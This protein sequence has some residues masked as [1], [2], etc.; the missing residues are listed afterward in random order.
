MIVNGSALSIADK[1]YISF[2]AVVSAIGAWGFTGQWSYTIL[3]AALGAITTALPRIII[4]LTGARK[5]SSDIM[6][7]ELRIL[8][9]QLAEERDTVRLVRITKHNLFSELQKYSYHIDYLEE[10]LKQH[11]IAHASL[12]RTDFTKITHFEDAGM[13]LIHKR[14]QERE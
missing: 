11:K 13:A 6:Q 5:S 12:I 1:V 4:A 14:I 8:V 10:T 3:A 7:S 2:S 9:L